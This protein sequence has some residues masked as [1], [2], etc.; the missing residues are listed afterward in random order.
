MS[1]FD[2]WNDEVDRI[3]AIDLN[4]E[5][6]TSMAGPTSLR[7]NCG[8]SYHMMSIG[9]DL[10]REEREGQSVGFGRSVIRPVNI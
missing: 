10:V 3:M 9:L 4:G 6:R 8:I 5:P 1:F 2:W 7:T